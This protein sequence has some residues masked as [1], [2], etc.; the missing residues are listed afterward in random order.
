M[1]PV[2]R[3]SRVPFSF[4]QCLSSLSIHR[5]SSLCWDYNLLVSLYEDQKPTGSLSFAAATRHFLPPGLPALQLRARPPTP[6][7]ERGVQTH[8]VLLPCLFYV[9]VIRERLCMRRQEH[10]DK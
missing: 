9:S 10:T 3:H 8:H 5:I 1:F 4:C 2:Y 6:G 7:P